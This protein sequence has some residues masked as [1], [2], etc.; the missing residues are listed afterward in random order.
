V[1][2]GEHWKLYREVRFDYLVSD[3]DNSGNHPIYVV[4]DE[5]VSSIFHI[6]DQIDETIVRKIIPTVEENPKKIVWKMSFDG[7]CSKEGSGMGLL[8]FLLHRESFLCHKK[9]NLI[10]PTISKNMK[11]FCWDW[12]LLKI[13]V[14]TKFMF[15][16]IMSLSSIKLKKIIRSNNRG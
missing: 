15:L 1:F 11:L 8:L 14:L 5:L 16:E 2:G 13:W 9:W 6:C 3:H 4:E 7:A 10:Q 12:K